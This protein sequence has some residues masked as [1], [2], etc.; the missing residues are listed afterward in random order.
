MLLCAGK[1][2]ATRVQNDDDKGADE[3]NNV[4]SGGVGGEGG[5]SC[6]VSRTKNP[7]RGAI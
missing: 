5:S 7:R 1:K 4:Q 6:Q 2:Q 3:D